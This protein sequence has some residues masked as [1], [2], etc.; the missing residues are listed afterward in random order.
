MKRYRL[1]GF[2]RR[3]LVRSRLG[4]LFAFAAMSLLAFT[5]AASAST[6]IRIS[7]DGGG[8]IAARVSEIES[9]RSRGQK[10]EI[11]VGYC[12]SACTLYLGLPNT[13]VSP[14]ARFGFHGPQIAT[15]GL[16][17]LPSQFEKWSQVMANHY[18]RPLRNWFMNSA[19]HSTDLITI[20]G[21]QLIALGVSQCV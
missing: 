10:V 3:G 8:S 18:P 4:N 17:M 15:K 12:N 6:T 16:T 20:K 2:G 14:G 13:C 7:N 19:R 9:I 1:R 11:R 21:D 5:P